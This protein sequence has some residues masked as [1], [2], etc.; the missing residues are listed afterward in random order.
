VKR[1]TVTSGGDEVQQVVLEGDPK[2]HPE[3]L[4]FRVVLPWGDLDVARCEDDTYW[5]H[6]RVNRPGDQE[7]VGD[8][9]RLGRILDARID[10]R[11]KHAG[12]IDASVLADPNLYHLAVRLGP[13][14]DATR[15]RR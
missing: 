5:I 12:T 10:A 2:K 9:A 1:L 14:P 6:F 8:G 13:D 15:G 7:D 4:H 3:P 11:D